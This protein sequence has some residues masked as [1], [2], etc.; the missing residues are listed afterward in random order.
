MNLY[1]QQTANR[2]KTWLIMMAFV[3]FL[4]VLG[5]GFDA[6]YVGAAGG[7]VPIGTIAALGVGS[8]SAVASYYNGDRAVLAATSARPVEEVAA[9]ASESDK[10]K[11]RQ[12]ENVVDE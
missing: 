9:G 1:E 2:R 11:L 7:Y 6:F 8:V 5:L 3:G 4:L 10:F 12:L